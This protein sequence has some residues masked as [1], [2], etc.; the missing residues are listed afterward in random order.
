[1]VEAS[2]VAIMAIRNGC[3]LFVNPHGARM[4]GF[5]GPEAMVGTPALNLVAPE[6]KA[7]VAERIKRLEEGKHNP[8]TQVPLI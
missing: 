8:L 3:F 1:M 5:S 4:L 2:P 7:E 6:S